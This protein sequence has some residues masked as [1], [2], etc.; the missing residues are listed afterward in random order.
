[1]QVNGSVR[2][3]F[4]ATSKRPVSK[5]TRKP[6]PRRIKVNKILRTLATL[7]PC[8]LGMLLL[9]VSMPHLA[10]GFQSVTSCGPLAGWLLA[11]AV[12]AAQ[13]VAKLQLTVVAH[14]DG[15]ASKW[16]PWQYVGA[17]IVG[18]TCLLSCCM[19]VMAFAAG[20]HGMG[21]QILAWTV[22]ILLPFLILAL[23]YTGSC[24]ALRK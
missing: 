15:H 8:G 22:G 5:R 1:M 9:G 13:V 3:I 17:G 14:V 10:D 19:N 18:V 2:D 16:Q 20:A 6:A 23:S 4:P 21:A 7:G 24:F 11:I 12:D